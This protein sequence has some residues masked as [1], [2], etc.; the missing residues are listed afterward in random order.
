MI[1]HLFVLLFISTSIGGT[2][3][4]GGTISYK[5]V[6]YNGSGVIV[7]ITQS[8]LYSYSRIYCNNTYIANQWPVS[9]AGYPDASATLTCVADCSTSGG[10]SPIPVTPRCTDYSSAMDIT[11]GQR[12]D[13]VI[14]QN[15]SYFRIAFASSAWRNLSLPTGVSTKTW[16]LSTVI[17]LRVRA[18]GRW[19]TPPIATMISPIYIP[20]GIQ[21]TISIPTIDADNDNVRCRFASGTNECGTVCPPASLPSGTTISNDCVLSITG[22]NAGDWY[23]ATIEVFCSYNLIFNMN[24]HF[25]R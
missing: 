17:D 19:N 10:Y 16:S 5:V 22:A 23:A 24:L 20:V 21:Q 15:G 11:V 25:H 18:D 2:H 6:G 14:L 12:T 3:F 8:Y 4:Q 1:L 9:L 7:R 13:D